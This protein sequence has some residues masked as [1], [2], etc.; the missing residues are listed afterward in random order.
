[1]ENRIKRLVHIEDRIHNKI[2]FS[3]KK[4]TEILEKRSITR[5]EKE[6]IVQQR[7]IQ[8]K[9]LT[10]KKLKHRIEKEIQKKQRDNKMYQLY[11]KRKVIYQKELF[12]ERLSDSKR[13]I[14]QKK[15]DFSIK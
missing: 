4:A 11:E 3:E 15:N 8:K 5:Q 13:R 7:E 12:L 10:E 2:K 6:K 9:L 14:K 1:M